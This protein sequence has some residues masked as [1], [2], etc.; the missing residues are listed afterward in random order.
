[1]DETGQDNRL[2]EC[3]A[4]GNLGLGDGEVRCCDRAMRPVEEAVPGAVEAPS[5]DGL[6]TTVFDMS[7]AGL[8]VCLCL[9]EGGEGTAAELAE[10]TDY[11]RSVVSRHLNH[12]ADLG[13]LEKQR[14][15]LKQGGHVYVYAPNEAPEVRE[16]FR[17]AFLGWVAAAGAEIDELGREKVEAI[18]ESETAEPQW[19]VFKE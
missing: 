1:M 5:L 15:L 6:L 10:Q 12:L 4:C 13:V 18:V 14:R 16:S 9:M 17:R 2:L 3:D 7:E 19:Q 8:D 11:D